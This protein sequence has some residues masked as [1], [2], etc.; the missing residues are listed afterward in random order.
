[1]LTILLLHGLGFGG[2]LLVQRCRTAEKIP[3]CWIDTGSEAAGRMTV[4]GAAAPAFCAA[5]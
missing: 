2:D 3:A 1:M 4:V 5:R